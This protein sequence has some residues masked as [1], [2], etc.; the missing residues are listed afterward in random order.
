MKNVAYKS[1]FTFLSII[2]SLGETIKE[3][4]KLIPKEKGPELNPIP[5]EQRKAE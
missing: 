1:K 2:N 4:Q 3:K 5:I